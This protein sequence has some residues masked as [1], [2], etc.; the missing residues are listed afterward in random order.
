MSQSYI[1][2][3]NNEKNIKKFAK[4]FVKNK[5]KYNPDFIHIKGKILIKD[6]NYIKEN[7]KYKSFSNTSRVVLI[8]IDDITIDAQ[9]S[10]LKILEENNEDT[11][12]IISINNI[13]RLLDTIKSRCIIEKDETVSKNNYYIESFISMNLEER[14]SFIDNINDTEDFIINVFSY[15]IENYKEI[16]NIEEKLKKLNEIQ[17][18]L[19]NNISS[20]LL[21]TDLALNI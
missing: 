15:I 5:A 16:D 18:S 8:E 1:Y 2:E 7:L 19:H 14:L 20:K 9:N 3:S 11:T 10:M 17:K 4:N 6:I 13:N 12:I 21:L